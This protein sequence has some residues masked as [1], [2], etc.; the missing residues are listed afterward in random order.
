MKITKGYLKRIIKEELEKELKTTPANEES[1]F[2]TNIEKLQGILARHELDAATTGTDDWSTDAGGDAAWDNYRE[3]RDAVLADPEYKD[4]EKYFVGFKVKTD[5]DKILT[6]SRLSLPEG[7]FGYGANSAVY[8]MLSDP[9]DL[10]KKGKH[11]FAL[12][13]PREMD[14]IM[15]QEDYVDPEKVKEVIGKE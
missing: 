15:V 7:E 8:L 12:G 5:N 1:K 6:I 2:M 10:T 13:K 4:L 14:S 9:N 11:R 3:A